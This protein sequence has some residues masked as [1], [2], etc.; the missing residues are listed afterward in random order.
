MMRR[1]SKTVGRDRRSWAE[2][3]SEA[4]EAEQRLVE[5]LDDDDYEPADAAPDAEEATE[6]DSHGG[7]DDA[8][9]LYLRQMGA[10]PLLNREQE[11]AL[12][13]KL[14]DARRRFRHAALCSGR[15]LLR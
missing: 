5:D 8:L 13:R 14:E 15:V 2:D 1:T 3:V 12:A 9:G 7:A 6:A 11:L 10:I 4:P